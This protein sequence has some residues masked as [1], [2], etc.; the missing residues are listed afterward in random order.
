MSTQAVQVQPRPIDADEG[1]NQSKQSPQLK[2]SG[3]S[4]R[5]R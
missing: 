4:D 1:S 5:G 3:A 2:H